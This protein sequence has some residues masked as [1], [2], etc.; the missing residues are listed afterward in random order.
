[1]KLHVRTYRH[2]WRSHVNHVYTCARGVSRSHVEHHVRTWNS[3]FACQPNIFASTVSTCARGAY[4]RTWSLKKTRGLTVT[5]HRISEI[6]ESLVQLH[7]SWSITVWYFYLLR[8]GVCFAGRQEYDRMC[9]MSLA[10][11]YFS[12]YYFLLFNLYSVYDFII[13]IYNTKVFFIATVSQK[14]YCF[15]RAMRCKRG[16]CCHAV[17]VPL[18]VCLSVTFVDHVKTNKDIFE[19]CS[20]SGSDTILVF[21]YQRGFWYSDGNPPNGGVECKGVG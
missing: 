16:L 11:T 19:I 20:P 14:L 21:P 4:V 5:D 10:I 2:G 3:T 18:S 13:N 12:F 7:S 8:S 6:A 9:S 17:S 15:Y 1:M